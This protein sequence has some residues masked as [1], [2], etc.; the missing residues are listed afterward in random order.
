MVSDLSILYGCTIISLTCMQFTL[1]VSESSIYLLAIFV[2]AFFILSVFPFFALHPSL[3]L[4]IYLCCIFLR[5][6]YP[7]SAA[8]QRIAFMISVLLSIPTISSPSLTGKP[9]NP[10]SIIFFAA[11]LMSSFT[12]IE[13]IGETIMSSA[14]TGISF[15]YL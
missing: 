13:I 9:V 11:A 8:F 5:R 3:L 1:C 6:I 7:H 10:S 4:A 14:V 15:T 12:S 2:F